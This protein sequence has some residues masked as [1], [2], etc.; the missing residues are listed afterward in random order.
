MSLV[1]FDQTDLGEVDTPQRQRRHAD[2]NMTFTYHVD[3]TNALMVATFAANHADHY[4]L[5][6]THNGNAINEAGRPVTVLVQVLAAP[7]HPPSSSIAGTKC[8]RMASIWLLISCVSLY[9]DGYKYM[10]R[11]S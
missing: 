10:Y 3:D 11:R 6:L 2:G 4:M 1:K 8:Y 7:P 9:R 5:T